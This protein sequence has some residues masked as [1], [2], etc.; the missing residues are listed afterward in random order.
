MLV[1]GLKARV[2][3]AFTQ[4]LLFYPFVIESLYLYLLGFFVP[5]HGHCSIHVCLRRRRVWGPRQLWI[6]PRYLTHHMATMYRNGTSSRP[7]AHRYLGSPIP[8]SPS[9]W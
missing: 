2:R 9:L 5:G 8:Y 4:N 1:A 3:P 7:V 6:L